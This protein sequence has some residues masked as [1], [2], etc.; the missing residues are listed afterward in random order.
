M[1]NLVICEVGLMAWKQIFLMGSG[2][3]SFSG[4]PQLSALSKGLKIRWL[5]HRGARVDPGGP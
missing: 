5:R 1:T 2:K 3:E 4:I